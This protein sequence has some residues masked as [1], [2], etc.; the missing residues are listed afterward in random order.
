MSSSKSNTKL[1]AVDTALGQSQTLLVRRSTSA[2]WKSPRLPRSPPPPITGSPR[3]LTRRHRAGS[4]GR[5]T[6]FSRSL[7]K[8]QGAWSRG[9]EGGGQQARGRGEMTYPRR[10]TLS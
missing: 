7:S 2:G 8:E 5:G 3:S 6:P 4:R 10:P 9:G 1:Q